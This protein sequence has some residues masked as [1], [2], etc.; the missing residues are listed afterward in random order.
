M[1]SSISISQPKEKQLNAILLKDPTK[2][3]KTYRNKQW[4]YTALCVASVTTA[5]FVT[6]AFTYAGLYISSTYFIGLITLEIF[7]KAGIYCAEQA[8]NYH[9]L[10]A[11]EHS[12]I[13][14]KFKDLNKEV[15]TYNSKINDKNILENA[16]ARILLKKEQYKDCEKQVNE[17]LNIIGQKNLDAN[18]KIENIF[19]MHSLNEQKANLKLQMVEIHHAIKNPFKEETLIDKGAIKSYNFVTRQTL[20]AIDKDSNHP[21]LNIFFKFNDANTP[22]LSRRGILELSLDA[23][24][25]LIFEGK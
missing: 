22:P 21:P 4:L 15:S 3:E 12:I 17:C 10:R 20:I 9:K 2:L 14:K 24:E 19:R 18:T 23:L 25:Q 7:T 6:A 8:Q 1:S 5:L 11:D 16:C 13:T